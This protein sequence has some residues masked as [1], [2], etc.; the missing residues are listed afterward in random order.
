[1]TVGLAAGLL[2]RA[3]QPQPL[4]AKPIRRGIVVLMIATVAGSILFGLNIKVPDNASA[5]ITLTD[6]APVDGFRMA[7][8][9]VRISPASTVSDDPEWVT[10][11]AWQGGGDTLHGLVIDRLDR[12]GPGHYRST[13]PVPVSGTWKTVFRI[14]DGDILT[15]APIYL[16]GDAAI[17]AAEVSALP[18]FTRPLQGEIEMLQRERKFDHPA[19]LFSLATWVVAAM[20]IILIWVLS[21]GAARI[22]DSYFGTATVPTPAPTP[23]PEAA[24]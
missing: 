8:A 6:A 24:V 18:T 17:G 3:L 4:P 2:A 15:G 1:M 5:T 22:N 9:D 10:I 13:K 11:L 20:T 23:V 14:Q 7:T 16:A 21:W 19:W 12:V